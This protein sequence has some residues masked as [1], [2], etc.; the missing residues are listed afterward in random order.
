MIKSFKNASIKNKLR[1]IIL[2][3][4]AIVLSISTTA[5]VVGDLIAFRRDMVHNLFILADL[6]GINSIAGLLF[7]ESDTATENISALKAN[8]HIVVTYI[9]SK[10]GNLFAG[11]FKEGIPK[12]AKFKTVA[13]YYL[14]YSLEPNDEG[15][16]LFEDEHV[17]ILKPIIFKGNSLGI[18]YI[19]S[20][21]TAFN[22]RLLWGVIIVIF[23]LTFSLLLAFLLASRLQ[24][25]ITKPIYQLLTVMTSIADDKGYS[26]RATKI[27]NDE[28]GT[29]TLGFNN[30][31]NQIEIRNTELQAYRDGLEE[32]VATRTDELKKRTDELVKSS[33]QLAKARD[34]AMAANK[35]KSAF[36]ANMSHELRTPLNGILG[37]AQ[38][39]ERDKSL[40]EKYN[41][42]INIIQ[43]SG[44]YLLTLISDILDLSKIEADRIELYP[45]DFHFDDF[46]QNI[47]DIFQMRTKQKN[48]AFMYE[49]LS[50]LPTGIHADEKRLRQILINL[51][52]NAIKFTDKGGVSFKIGYH[53]NRIRFQIEDTGIGIAEND[54]DKIFTPFQQV[55]DQSVQT[56]GTG[57]GLSITK[58]LTEIMG[59]KLNVES[60]FGKGSTFW[61][62]LD[63]PNIA[64]FVKPTI[65]K[66]PNIIGIIGESHKILIVDDKEANRLVLTNLL[67]P[68]G[69]EI[70][71]AENGQECIKIALEEKPDLILTDLVMPIMDGF[72]ATRQI[73]RI[74]ELKD[75]IIIMISASVFDYYKQQSMEAGCDDFLPKPIRAEDLLKQLGKYL[76][77]NWLYDDELPVENILEANEL[78][79][80]SKEQA[81]IIFDLAMKG[82]L[83]KVTKQAN[84]F[85][86][87]NKNLQQFAEKI[88]ELSK[89][90]EEEEICDLIESYMQDESIIE[91]EQI[92]PS[93]EQAEILFDLAMKGNL[94]K[95]TKQANEFAQDNK[96]LQQ[97]AE[98]ISE[99]AKDFE[100]E[101]ICNLIESYMKN[102]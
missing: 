2:F 71:E 3:T 63:L 102:K 40:P 6:V 75:V 11:Y 39:M 52:S 22:E 87:D 61:L 51:L 73:R 23:V 7:D 72:E 34:E 12:Q 96:N 56:E 18:V 89:D 8:K 44:Q 16:F 31:L 77:L 43:N 65:K 74:P 47:I 57:L 55:G 24:Q 49:K 94:S 27:T 98:K 20:D 68:L 90:F 45:T 29:L 36:L 1:V 58:K 78:I 67:S 37:Y 70:F 69:F 50:H 97:F 64:G 25:V 91:T 10:D 62:T 32:M 53:N 84:E 80:P 41:A 76:K 5:Y 93:K 28:L 82:N 66:E 9:F 81:E 86:Q 95:T 33:E 99:L 48:I 79:G 21:L 14:N 59:G 85:A 38:I 60:K 19:Q 13:E 92:G 100:E 17:N 46:L 30:M 42:G 101:E 35:A 26:H 4:S 15:N 88:S 83:S 54:I